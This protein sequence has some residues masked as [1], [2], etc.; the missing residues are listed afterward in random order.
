M[1]GKTF[2]RGENFSRVIKDSRRAKKIEVPKKIK[3]K[4][5]KNFWV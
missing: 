5:V 4:V 3:K 1:V 2:R